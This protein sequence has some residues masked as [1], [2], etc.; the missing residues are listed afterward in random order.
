[1]KC[2]IPTIMPPFFGKTTMITNESVTKDLDTD[3]FMKST[4]KKN[5]M[6]CKTDVCEI[7]FANVKIFANLI[8]EVIEHRST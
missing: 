7:I 5:R 6:C 1:M 4:T 3:S 2:I 8:Q